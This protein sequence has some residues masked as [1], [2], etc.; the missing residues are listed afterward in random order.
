MLKNISPEKLAI[1]AT[2]IAIDISKNKEIEDIYLI[3][4]IMSQISDVLSTIINQRI[5]LKKNCDF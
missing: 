4:T 2:E 1:L 3:K 5:N